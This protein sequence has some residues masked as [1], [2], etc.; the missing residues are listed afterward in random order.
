MAEQKLH[1]EAQQVCDL[2]VASGRPP[3]ETLSPPEARDGLSRHRAPILQPDP[4]EVAEV[5]ALKA[6]GPAGPIPLRLYRGNGAD[7]GPAAAG[8]RLFSRRRLGDRRPRKPRP[9]LPRPR[10]CHPVH[11]RLRRLS[12]GARAQVSGRRRGCHRRDALDRGQTRRASASMRARH[13]GRRRQRRRQPRR[14]RRRSMRAIEAGPRLGPAGADLPAHRHAHGLS[15][16][17]SATPQQ[18]PLTR[19][20]DAT[21]SSTTTC[22]S[23]ATRPTGAPRR[24]W[25]PDSEGLAAGSRHHRRLRSARR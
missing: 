16:A 6:E 14:R 11:R 3:I 22:A 12:A 24:C 18:L 8:A 25:R 17:P 5:L 19:R 15:L 9:G 13:R 20:G 2:I 1:P 7:E 4:P 10:Q 21:G 23:E